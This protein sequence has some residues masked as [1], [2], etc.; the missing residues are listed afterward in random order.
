[1]GDHFEIETTYKTASREDCRIKHADDEMRLAV[2]I[3]RSIPGDYSAG[4]EKLRKSA[5][6]H[7][8]KGLHPLQDYYAHMNAGVNHRFEVFIAPFFHGELFVGVPLYDESFQIIMP[9]AKLER[10]FDDIHMDYIATEQNINGKKIP[11]KGWI[12][13][14]SPSNNTRLEATKMAT[15]EY[16]REFCKQT[17]NG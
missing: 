15:E 17:E 10:M 16:F 1:L 13:R 2:E 3:M 11:F 4:S 7:L 8:G 6:Q 5:L 12:K 9:N 14:T